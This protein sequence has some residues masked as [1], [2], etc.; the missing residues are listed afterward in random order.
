MRL[1]SPTSRPAWLDAFVNTQL[2]TQP[3][4]IKKDRIIGSAR[5]S[6]GTWAVATRAA[7]WL[8]KD[9]FSHDDAASADTPPAD[10]AHSPT[11]PATAPAPEVVGGPWRWTQM[12]AA[13]WDGERARLLLTWAGSDLGPDELVFPEDTPDAFA[14]AVRAGVQSSLVHS[15]YVSLPSGGFGRAFIRR[16]PGGE[17]SSQLVIQ[18]DYSGSAQERQMLI[19]LEAAAREAAGMQF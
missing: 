18:G 14:Q 6:D 7:L 16:E 4:R 1:S 8:I 10:A 2:H 19:D 12:L 9:N 17:L 13:E 5:M 11:S 15:Q 3:R